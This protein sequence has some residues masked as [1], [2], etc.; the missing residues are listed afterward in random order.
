MVPGISATVTEAVGQSRSGAAQ[1]DP[2][3]VKSHPKVASFAGQNTPKNSCAV[4]LPGLQRC[5]YGLR[6]LNRALQLLVLQ[7]FKKKQGVRK[8]ITPAATGC[9]SLQV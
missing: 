9:I 2:Q 6:G 3:S 8:F 5:W 4:P 1:P 7:A